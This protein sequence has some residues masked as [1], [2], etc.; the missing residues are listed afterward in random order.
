MGIYVPFLLLGFTRRQLARSRGTACCRGGKVVLNFCPG[1]FSSSVGRKGMLKLCL[2]IPV[3]VSTA[4][5]F[6]YNIEC[7]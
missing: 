3:V 7:K 5:S 2:C 1:A 6:I 4:A